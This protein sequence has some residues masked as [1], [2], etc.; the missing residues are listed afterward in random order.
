[1]K[2][3]LLPLL[4]AI[5]LPNVVYS[6]MIPKISDYEL[7]SKEGERFEFLCPKEKYKENGQTRKKP[8][9]KECWFELNEEYINFMDMQKIKREDI[10]AYW[11]FKSPHFNNTIV[12]HFIYY[13]FKGEIKKIV[14]QAKP[15]N[16]TP[17]FESQHKKIQE[18]I[19]VWINQ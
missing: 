9:Y 7:L 5:A 6:G 16:F 11:H 14:I 19:T 17:P 12:E 15:K 8:M 13:K 4:A 3:L 2:R 18:A 1:M 10:F